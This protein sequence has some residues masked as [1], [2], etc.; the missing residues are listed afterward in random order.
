MVKPQ[1]YRRPW[2]EICNTIWGITQRDAQKKILLSP[3][4]LFLGG[5]S[6]QNRFGGG[7]NPAKSIFW[8]EGGQVPIRKHAQTVTGPTVKI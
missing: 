4:N 8:G 7:A 6:L 1:S 2:V 5:L 3:Q